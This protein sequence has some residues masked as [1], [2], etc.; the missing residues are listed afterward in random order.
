MSRKGF[1]RSIESVGD[2]IAFLWEVLSAGAGVEPADE[3]E[4]EDERTD[5]SIDAI[6]VEG[7]ELE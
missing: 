6:D 7:E 5:P 2:A 1:E 4:D 3:D